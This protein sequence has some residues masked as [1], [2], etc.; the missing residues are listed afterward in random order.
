MGCCGLL[1]NEG[2]LTLYE[3]LT[4]TIYLSGMFACI[5]IKKGRREALNASHHEY[6]YIVGYVYLI[7]KI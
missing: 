2:L 3:P 5:K 1:L 7:E 6:N 4:R